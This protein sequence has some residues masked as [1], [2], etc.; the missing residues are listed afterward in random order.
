[1]E[2]TV[3]LTSNGRSDLLERTI[4]SFNNFNTHPIADFIII[5]DSG[6]PGYGK[7][8]TER[9]PY[10]IISNLKN[11][12][13]VASIDIAYREV[14]TPYIFHMEEDWEFL[15]GS[16]IEHSLWVLDFDPKIM[17]VWL[18]RMHELPD[19]LARHY[20]NGLEFQYK[21]TNFYGWHGFTFNP[22]LRRLLDYKQVAPYSQYGNT[23]LAEK[24][25]GQA[26]Y[27]LGFRAAILKDEY[28]RHIG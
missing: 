25:I 20:V 11:I 27:D 1:M 24:A 16:F 3:V 14:R 17:T 26:Y 10:H 19:E 15:K 22:G 7:I 13:Q 6:R 2:V 4:K 8:L 28:V 12:G 9:Y 21:T 23:G 18:N 5:D